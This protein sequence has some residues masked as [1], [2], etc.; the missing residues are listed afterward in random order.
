[1]NIKN[2]EDGVVGQSKLYTYK[3]RAECFYDVTEF[4]KQTSKAIESIKSSDELSST[5]FGILSVIG[6]DEIPDVTVIFKSN[7]NLLEVKQILSEVENGH[8]MLETIEL[9][10]NYTG[11]RFRKQKSNVTAIQ[12]TLSKIKNTIALW[13]QGWAY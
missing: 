4:Y 3:F 9:I 8:V 12:R 11:V 13:A 2:L 1:M 7:F 10:E 5:K 6:K